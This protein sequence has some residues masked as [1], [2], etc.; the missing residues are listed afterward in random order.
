[1]G[2]PQGQVDFLSELD[3]ISLQPPL[4]ANDAGPSET[5]ETESGS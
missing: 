3:P 5:G 2:K 4:H 1:M